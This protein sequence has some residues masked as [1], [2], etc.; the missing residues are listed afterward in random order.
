MDDLTRVAALIR[1]YNGISDR[2]ATLVGRLAPTGHVSEFI[3]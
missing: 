3:A 2:I 1:E